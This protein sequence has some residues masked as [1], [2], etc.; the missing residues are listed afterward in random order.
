[1]PAF[2]PTGATARRPG[3]GVGAVLPMD[4]G[5]AGK[6]LS[7]DPDESSAGWGPEPN[8]SGASPLSAPRWSSRVA[9]SEASRSPARSIGP[10]ARRVVSTPPTLSPPPTRSRGP[11]AVDGGLTSQGPSVLFIRRDGTG[12]CFLVLFYT[13]YMLFGTKKAAGRGLDPVRPTARTLRVAGPLCTGRAVASGRWRVGRGESAVAS[14]QWRVGTRPPGPAGFCVHLAAGGEQ[15]GEEEVGGIDA[16]SVV[17][18]HREGLGEGHVVGQPALSGRRHRVVAG[19]H[20]HGG[21]DVGRV[22][23]TLAKSN[24]LTAS[25]ACRRA[26][27]IAEGAGPHRPPG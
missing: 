27:G 14:G 24:R 25:P 15:G 12:P 6:V 1:M 18:G 2:C 22:E 7:D 3:N 10:P 19:R 5:S 16:G 23:P 8:R 26:R 13:F 11:W 9:S 4:G 21:G 20:A 17:G